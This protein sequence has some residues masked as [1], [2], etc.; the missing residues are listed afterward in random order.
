MLTPNFKIL[1]WNVWFDTFAQAKR[2]EEILRISQSYSPDIICFQEVTDPFIESLKK[3]PEL[4]NYHVSDKDLD[5]STVHPYGVLSLIKKDYRNVEFT[6]HRFPT[7]MARRLLVTSFDAPYSGPL[8]ASEVTVEPKTDS[9]PTEPRENSNIKRIAIGNVHL[10][11]L[12]SRPYREQ[13]LAISSTILSSYAYAILCGD[14]N[15]C[16]YRNYEDLRSLKVD[17]N[18]LENHSLAKFLPNF[19]DTWPRLFPN[20]K[21]YTFHGGDND[22]VPNKVE[23]MRYDRIC[24]YSNPTIKSELAQVSSS[25]DTI[26]ERLSEPMIPLEMI[27]LGDQPI[28]ASPSSDSTNPTALAD[29]AFSS[30]PSNSQTR[31]LKEFYGRALLNVFPSDHYGLL[32]NYHINYDLLNLA[33]TEKA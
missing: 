24:Y 20:D 4:S 29:S 17:P 11:S 16:S 32:A 9:T 27:I 5:G 25:T 7:N 8:D 19:T 21:G 10:E 18:T 23:I 28:A 3:W 13:Q 6:F 26:D 2:Y 33:G 31:P 15:F 14:F 1:T 12:G 30:P 22:M